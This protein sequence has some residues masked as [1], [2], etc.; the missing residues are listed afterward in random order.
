MNSDSKPIAIDLFAGC[1]GLTCGLKK[2][3]FQVV[4]ALE[5]NSLAVQTYRLNHPE[6]SVSA[7]DIREINPEEWM[8]ELALEVGEL[9]LLAGCPP[10]QGFSTLRTNNGAKSNRDGRNS[11]VREMISLIETFLPKTVLMENVPGLKSKTVFKQFVRELKRLKYIPEEEI[12]DVV[13]YGVPQK[14]KRLVLA[15]GYKFNVPFAREVKGLKTVRSVLEDLP[16]AGESGDYWHDYPESRTELMMERI[17][18]T[19]QDGGSR[20]SW[21]DHLW[22]DCHRKTDGFKDVYGR[23]KWD[24]AAPTITGG[25][26]NPS[27]GRFLHPVEDRGITL[28]E[29]ALIQSFPKRYKFP[30]SA[31]KQEVALMIGNAIPPEFVKLQGNAIRRA[32]KSAESEGLLS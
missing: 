14:R 30:K 12:H 6:V 1:G 13:K 5:I 22:L 21:P 32:I 8:K 3:G 9:D 24:A 20:S 4:G 17:R 28:R 10:C 15:A 27:R 31:T 26:F 29:A 7:N 19:P 25:C 23:M 18:A 16:K 11:L 2:A